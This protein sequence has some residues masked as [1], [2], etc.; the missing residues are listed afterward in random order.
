MEVSPYQAQHELIHTTESQNNTLLCKI[1]KKCDEE[2][3]HGTLPDHISSDH[4]QGTAN[5]KP[6]NSL[7]YEVQNNNASTPKDD[8]SIEMYM[9]NTMDMNL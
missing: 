5:A 8:F 6:L 7:G 4:F 2:D 9:N 3:L 1:T